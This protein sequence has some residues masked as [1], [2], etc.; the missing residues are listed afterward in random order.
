MNHLLSKPLYGMAGLLLLAVLMAGLLTGCSQSEAQ[1]SVA[2]SLSSV[3]VETLGELAPA[4]N[5]RFVGRVDAVSSVDLSFQVGGRL[6]ELP[7]Q[8]G[9]LLPRG[10]LLAALDARDYQLALEQ[11]QVQQQQA[12]R[13]L[14]RKRSLLTNNSVPR[15]VVE[16]AQDQLRLAEL[17][18]ESAQRNLSYTRITA[19]SDVLIT[20]RLADRFVN[21]QPGT[22]VVRV[23]DVTEYRVHISVP[24]DLVRLVSGPELVEAELLLPGDEE[25]RL[26]LG[27]REHA[28]EPDQVVQTYQVTFGF[29]RPKDLN[30]LPGMTATVL[31][32]ATP[33]LH[34]ADQLNVP[35]AAL[36]SLPDGSL[37]LWVYDPQTSEVHQ[38]K[39]SVGAMGGERV[40]LIS[41]VQ[42]GEQVVTAG[43]TRLQEGM[44]VRPFSQ[45]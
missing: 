13:D 42:A 19:P 39:V 21:L 45:L 27:Y 20:R 44:R 35:V 37:Y 33:Q 25:Q 18:V 1:S 9:R 34:A 8:Q 17:A 28:T 3:K 6:T 32:T 15:A 22:P 12:R 23:Q 31:V 5:R 30:L 29:E 26:P 36:N 14:D 38:R 10:S 4:I 40:Q 41:G 2:E 43:T 11:A 16:E 24:E 7:V